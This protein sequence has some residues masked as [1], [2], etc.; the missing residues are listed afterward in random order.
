M[1]REGG[2]LGL[3]LWMLYD[4]LMLEDF[5]VCCISVVSPAS[6]QKN[7][8]HLKVPQRTYIMLDVFGRTGGGSWSLLFALL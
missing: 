1:D 5:A 6:A 3:I 7:N 2:R 8:K 4:G